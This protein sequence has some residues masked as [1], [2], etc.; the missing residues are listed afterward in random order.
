LP[1]KDGFA[2]G[3]LDYVNSNDHEVCELTLKGRCKSLEIKTN[4]RQLP[5]IVAMMAGYL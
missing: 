2:V 1:P 5:Q 4:I 3:I